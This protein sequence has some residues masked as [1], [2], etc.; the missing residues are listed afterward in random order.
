MPLPPL[1]HSQAHGRVL[2]RKVIYIYLLLNGKYNSN[3]KLIFKL[4]K[5]KLL[6]Q[7]LKEACDILKLQFL[8][9]ELD[10]KTRW[11]STLY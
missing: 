7:N 9:P 10:V 2:L 3:R 6:K 4:K 8:K 1:S 11:N 5:S